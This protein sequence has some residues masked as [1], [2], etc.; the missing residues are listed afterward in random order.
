MIKA[1]MASIQPTSPDFFKFPRANVENKKTRELITP[2]RITRRGSSRNL[3]AK[4]KLQPAKAA[5]TTNAVVPEL[6][7]AG[8]ADHINNSDN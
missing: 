8:N 7:C 2:A 1:T 5:A 4:R 6:C 3:L